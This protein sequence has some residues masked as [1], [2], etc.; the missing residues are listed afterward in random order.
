MAT[1]SYIIWNGNPEIFSVGSFALRWYG[2]FFAL[3]FLISQQILYYMF[4][5]EGKPEKDVDTLTIYMIVATILGARLG[6]VLFYQPEII[7]QEPLSIFLPF[8]FSPFKFTG[9]Q[10][11][12]SHGGAIGILF[13]LWLYSRKRKP[14]QNYF[15]ILDRIVILVALTGALIRL[16]NFFNSEIIGTPTDKPWGIVFTGRLT[17][18]LKD[19]RIDPDHIVKDMVYVQNDSLPAGENG[20]KPITIYIFFKPQATEA[21]AAGLINDRVVPLLSG[22][23]YEYFDETPQ[24]RLDY[25]IARP[26]AEGFVAKINTVGI[27]RHPGQLYEAISCVILFLVLFAIWNRHRQHLV[28]GRI[29]GIFLVWCFGMRIVIE[30]LKEN[31]EAFEDRL[32]IN[33]GQILSIPLVVAGIIILVY[34]SRKKESKNT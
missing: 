25:K 5:K 26:D 13:A 1:L 20:R 24:L 22:R 12:A 30:F 3:G 23:L 10:G 15:Q 33:M 11:L 17:E 4:R 34:T 27:A 6:H 8:E 31:Q 7:W 14:G 2:L 9:L 28:T 19:D 29:F 21:Q 18:S 16:G 32:P